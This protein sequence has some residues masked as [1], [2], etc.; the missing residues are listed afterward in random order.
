MSSNRIRLCIS[1]FCAL[2][3]AAEA[4]AAAPR[5]SVAPPPPGVT[6]AMREA[7]DKARGAAERAYRQEL[8]RF[9]KE[10]ETVTLQEKARNDAKSAPTKAEGKALWQKGLAAMQAA[11]AAPIPEE[12]IT[13]AELRQYLKDT[14]FPEK[15]IS[16]RLSAI[17][18]TSDAE[19]VFRWGLLDGLGAIFDAALAAGRLDEAR[20]AE[21]WRLAIIH[22]AD[23]GKAAGL[24]A[25]E[26]A[27]KL[28]HE[29]EDNLGRLYTALGDYPRAAR[30]F[31][32]DVPR[33]ASA[34]QL[35][36]LCKASVRE[37][38]ER[39]KRDREWAARKER[40]QAASEPAPQTIRQEGSSG[41]LIAP[42]PE[43][44]SERLREAVARALER[45]ERKSGIDLA[46][47]RIDF[48]IADMRETAQ[49][50][51]EQ[52]ATQEEKDRLRQ[53]HMEALDALYE[54]RRQE[55]PIS[56][57]AFREFLDGQFLTPEALKGHLGGMLFRKKALAREEALGALQPLFERALGAG[58]YSEAKTIALWQFAIA[59]EADPNSTTHPGA[60][61][62]GCQPEVIPYHK[63]LGRLYTAMKDWDKAVHHFG[64]TFRLP[65]EKGMKKALCAA[66]AEASQKQENHHSALALALMP[67]LQTACD[68]KKWDLAEKICQWQIELA[69]EA[70][71][72]A[73][74]ADPLAAQRSD[75]DLAAF[76]HNAGLVAK[77]KG[78]SFKAKEYFQKAL[79][80]TPGRKVLV[81]TGGEL[82]AA[83]DLAKIARDENEPATARFLSGLA[84][85]FL[86]R[87]PE[88]SV[89]QGNDTLQLMAWADLALGEYGR[90]LESAGTLVGFLNQTQWQETT[91]MA[92]ALGSLG[93]AQYF[94]GD[95]VGARQS[96]TRALALY[97]RETGADASEHADILLKMAALQRED[98]DSGKAFLDRAAKLAPQL[99]LLYRARISLMLGEA[100]QG[101]A[102]NAE[103]EYRRA[104]RSATEARKDARNNPAEVDLLLGDILLRLGETEQALPLLQDAFGH[105]YMREEQAQASRCGYLLQKGHAALGQRRAAI[106]WGKLGIG[107]LQQV[108]A[109]LRRVS[110]ENQQSFL[111]ARQYIYQDLI[112]LLQQEGRVQEAED[113]YSMLKKEEIRQFAPEEVRFRQNGQSP[114]MSGLEENLEDL[115]LDTLTT[116]R[117]VKDAVNM[118]EHWDEQSPRGYDKPTH[119]RNTGLVKF[120]AKG[121][122]VY[123]EPENQELMRRM[124][125][126]QGCSVPFARK[127]PEDI[128]MT[129]QALPALKKRLADEREIL[130]AFLRALPG[131]LAGDWEPEAQP[132]LQAAASHLDPG[133]VLLR[134][135]TGSDGLWL[136]LTDERRIPLK[137]L[138]VDVPRSEILRHVVELREII[139]Q[140]DVDPRPKCKVLYDLLIAPL[141]PDLE[142]LKPDTLLFSLD[143][144]LR[145]VPPAILYDGKQWLVEKYAT[146]VFLEASK[147][148]LEAKKTGERTMG[149]LGLSER[150][151]G[152]PALPGVVAELESIVRSDDS[153]DGVVPGRIYLNE[154]FTEDALASV[155]RDSTSLLHVATHFKL[156]PGSARDSFLLLG[157]GTRLPLSRL[158]EKQFNFGNLQQIA[159]SACET[160]LRLDSSGSEIESLGALVQEKG[161]Q[162]V[163]ATLWPIA[164]KATS[165]LMPLFYQNLMQGRSRAEALRQAQLSLI[166]G[167]W[168]DKLPEVRG[169]KNPRLRRQDLPGRSHPFYWGAFILMGDWR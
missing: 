117:G 58:D 124:L 121:E 149:A 97:E 42:P 62:A 126:S 25:Y 125:Q 7:V 127:Y 27:L 138:R 71:R 53:E 155:L 143:N 129:P 166:R 67:Y 160:G 98:G 48:Q 86:L 49:R 69:H 90:A 14:G 64:I 16:N 158:T 45:A 136:W 72:A 11:V 147:D 41:R 162:S 79:Q 76:Y 109:D 52:A 65:P 91:A 24:D 73:T 123:L 142:R 43:G 146:G 44:A 29:V 81:A 104:L 17:V 92:R 39:R 95:A 33:D 85:A 66:A 1:V 74:M 141:E 40:H 87:L 54:E 156:D 8:A 59:H 18:V 150:K 88:M 112:G 164:D 34:A 102:K 36:E 103:Q 50:R 89:A 19:Q 159:L 99:P 63:N 47:K 168:E 75:D 68:E 163:L 56:E 106:F 31:C 113:I 21:L 153:P 55:L 46:H 23:V 116:L 167:D 9:R 110:A 140:K 93:S 60:E 135:V 13:E 105:Y 3:L 82:R 114:E 5:L 6:P 122:P 118:A 119:L 151:E 78:E 28:D 80:P 10:W 145:Y 37:V 100:A 128:E 35:E 20:A 32:L 154:A 26:K 83:I 139:T 12:G 161:A 2:L 169:E 96:F 157:D 70:Q 107:A 38:E 57:E 165:V 130:R 108:R 120:D 15:N 22:K 134:A 152:F 137:L 30:Y 133:T 131:A 101:D 94:A 144:I 132:H 111:D 61:Y 115:L 51:E 77:E 84:W 148:S 4:C